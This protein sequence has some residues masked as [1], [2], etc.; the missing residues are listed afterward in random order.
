MLYRALST[1]FSIW[2]FATA[3]DSTLAENSKVPT[4]L[5]AL[6]AANNDTVSKIRLGKKLFFDK[7]LSRDGTISC[8]TC[9]KPDE[10]FTEYGVKTSAGFKGK[11]NRRNTPTLLNAAYYHRLHHDGRETALETQF[12]LPLTA[13]DEMASRSVGYVVTKLGWL[14]EYNE[15]FR[16]AFGTAPTAGAIGEA[17]AAYQRTLISAN[18]RFDRWYFGR[19]KGLLS[20]QEVA[21]FQLFTGKADCASCHQIG[22]KDALFTDQAFHDIGH[23]WEQNQKKSEAKDLGRYE[24]TLDKRDKW[25]FRTPTLRNVAVTAPYMHDGVFSTLKEVIE[26][27]NKGGAPHSG[28]DVRIKKLNLSKEEIESLEAFLKTLTGDNIDQLSKTTN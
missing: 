25:R 12:V 21:G 18:S 4:G 9:H 27:Y 1:F 14:P 22:D 16:E 8:A 13:H 23:G 10:A 20:K 5:P 6:P 11:K 3:A 24:V 28:Q 17:L 26:F 2:L 15:L 7:R 19:E